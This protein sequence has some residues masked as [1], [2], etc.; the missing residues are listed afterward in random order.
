[1]HLSY[2]KTKIELK[3]NQSTFYQTKSKHNG[4]TNCSIPFQ[5]KLLTARKTVLE[6]L[7]MSIIY[8]IYIYILIE[9]KG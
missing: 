4:I 5:N 9:K 7:I 8:I 3:H 1:M 2:F 6:N